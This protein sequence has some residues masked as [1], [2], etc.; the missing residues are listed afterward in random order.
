[1]KT[2]YD[3]ALRALQREVDELR[4]SIGAATNQLARI[5]TMRQTVDDAIRDEAALAA[6]DWT[7]SPQ[8]YLA[9][10]RAERVRLAEERLAA[11]ARLEAL[12]H[13]AMESYGSL[14]AIEGAAATYREEAERYAATAEQGRI[15]D[16]AGAR[17]ARA[18][19]RPQRGAA[20]S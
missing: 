13:E 16:F 8:A 3:T 4:T 2:P 18:L 10:A 15:D 9:R 19:R 12:R 14:R 6:A 7:F 5:E 17:F 20:R 11:D 1:M